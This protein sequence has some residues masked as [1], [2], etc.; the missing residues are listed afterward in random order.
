L[1]FASAFAL[2]IT[3]PYLVAHFSVG[4]E[5]VF[6]GFLFNPIDGSSYL[7]K[8]YQGWSGD[9][10]FTLPYTAI[11]G[12]GSYLFLFYLFLGHLSRLFNLP[13]ILVYHAARVVGAAYMLIALAAFAKFFFQNQPGL[14]RCAFLLAAL[15][16][17]VG[18][19]A[20]PL[21]EFTSDF[22]VAEAYPFLSAYATP[23]FAIGL[24]LLLTILFVSQ[25]KGSLKSS[26]ILFGA[27]ILLAIIQPFGVVVVVVVI[28]GKLLMDGLADRSWK[29]QVLLPVLVGGGMPLLYQFWVI[30]TDPL[31]SAWNS[32]NLTPAPP[33]WDLVLSLS[34][35]FLLAI[36]A[37]YQKWKSSDLHNFSLP[38]VWLIAGV[39]LIFLPFNLQRRFM[40]GMYI[41][42]AIL[43]IS[44]FAY[45][46]GRRYVNL[47]AML[48][49]ISI[50]TNLI[51]LSAGILGVISRDSA[52]Y[53]TQDE[54]RALHWVRLETEKDAVILS[55]PEMGRFIPAY[56]G[57]R[58]LYGHPFETVDAE[59]QEQ[60]V[61]DYLAGRIDIHQTGEIDY[62]FMG[63]REQ[64]LGAEYRDSGVVTVYQNNTVKIEKVGE[65]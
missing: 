44:T 14:G 46:E 62:I 48:I 33:L 18:W 3:V 12:E 5:Y 15:G 20:L 39:V 6:A 8:M 9:W 34:P 1:F 28:A 55:S 57:R 59:Q 11:K 36:Y 42:S 21:G 27:S 30:Q 32:Q 16:S 4:N 7:A 50:L 49:L 61:L 13:L 43:A 17:G 25:L 65:P 22:W 24:A 54:Y 35:A 60:L 51:I 40:I 45:L 58:V 2:L 23:H 29:W 63:P 41:P 52:I 64:Q 10:Q 19:L 56:T 38:I 53:L 31:L 47:R 37:I 26:L